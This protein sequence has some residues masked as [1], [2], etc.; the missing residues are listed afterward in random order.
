MKNIYSKIILTSV[1]GFLIITSL[2]QTVLAASD[3]LNRLNNAG[4]NAGFNVDKKNPAETTAGII[5]FVLGFLGVIFVCLMVY[6]GFLWM[7][8]AGNSERL[9][10]AKDILINASIGLAIVLAAYAITVFLFQYLRVAS[11]GGVGGT[12]SNPL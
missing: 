3:M 6:A 1:L 5:E 7:T 10:K 2:P 11:T 9:Q 4:V 12:G 8:A